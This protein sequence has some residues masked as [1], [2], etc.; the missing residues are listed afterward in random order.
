MG[1]GREAPWPI[2]AGRMEIRGLVMRI[3]QERFNDWQDALTGSP[4]IA[5]GITKFSNNR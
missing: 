1:V 4:P 2:P 3:E 5:A